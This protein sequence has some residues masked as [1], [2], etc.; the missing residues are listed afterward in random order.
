[1]HVF[2]NH[3][4]ICMEENKLKLMHDYILGWN[5]TT[6]EPNESSSRDGEQHC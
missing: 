2:K 4:N 1:M 3:L 5:R 6:Q